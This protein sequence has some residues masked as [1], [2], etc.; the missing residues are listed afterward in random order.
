MP[1]IWGYEY[2]CHTYSLGE[3]LFL[4]VKAETIPW[5]VRTSCSVISIRCKQFLIDLIID[6]FFSGDEKN[7]LPLSSCSRWSKKLT[8]SSFRAARV[9]PV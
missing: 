5:K 8:N 9:A 3:A 6:G 2:A 4:P 1:P 7:P